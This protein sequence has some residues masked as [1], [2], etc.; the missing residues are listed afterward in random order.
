MLSLSLLA[1][2][3]AGVRILCLGAHCDDIEIGCGGTV[4]Q[5][6]ERVPQAEVHWV[7]LSSDAVRAREAVDSAHAFL[8]RIA[9]KTIVVKDFRNSFFPFIGA[10]LKEYF[11]ALKTMVEPDVIF[12]H[13]REDLH[14]DHQL[15]SQL[16][17]NT[18]RN[19]L[20]LEY[21]VPKYDGDLGAPSVFTHLPEAVCHR[22][23]AALM[24]HFKSQVDKHWFDEQTFWALL[25][26]RGMES[27]SPSKY[28]EAFY[29]R[30]LVV[31]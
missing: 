7:V 25:R 22:K 23:V 4:L 14:Q 12:T 6:L 28:A 19:H 27:N 29:C 21:E 18:F 8:D 26:L 15:V 9:A 24:T 10:T 1:P 17:W 31:G 5:L 2:H 3:G 30:K 13:R 16:T 20:I 11:E